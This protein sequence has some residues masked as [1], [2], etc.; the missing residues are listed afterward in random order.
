M[1]S[2][3]T[4][5]IVVVGVLCLGISFGRW[6]TG[7]QPPPKV[8]TKVLIVKVPV[9][10]THIEYRDKYVGLPDHCKTVVSLLSKGTV[11]DGAISLS[12]GQILDALADL[13]K[14][15]AMHSTFEVNDAITRIRAAQDT[16]DNNVL[17]KAAAKDALVSALK[18]CEQEVND[19]P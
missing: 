8:E 1:T 18:S 13:G 6:S 17:E 12:S 5:V 7:G 15:D 2:P 11:N 10:K 14:A 19:G 9:V 16:L 3:R 4:R